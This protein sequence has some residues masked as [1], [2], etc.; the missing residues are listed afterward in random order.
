[1]QRNKQATTKKQG[2]AF[3][4]KGVKEERLNRSHVC[5]GRNILL[6]TQFK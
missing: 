5:S 4:N 2:S 6:P 1:M 3:I